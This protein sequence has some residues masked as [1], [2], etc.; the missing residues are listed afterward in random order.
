MTN[1]GPIVELLSAGLVYEKSWNFHS[2]FIKTNPA[3]GNSNFWS[4]TKFVRGRKETSKVEM[5]APSPN[6]CNLQVKV[7]TPVP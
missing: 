4:S 7:F 1:S 6:E 3:Q 2:P 5:N